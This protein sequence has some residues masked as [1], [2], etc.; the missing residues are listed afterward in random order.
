MAN[1]A[2]SVNA[3]S[4]FSDY[5]DKRKVENTAKILKSEGVDIK[6]IMKSTG[7]TKKEIENL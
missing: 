3:K 2:K 7:L 6:I 5:V 4:W 1:A